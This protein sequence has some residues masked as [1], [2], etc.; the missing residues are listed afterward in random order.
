MNADLSPDFV[1]ITAT[2]RR[3]YELADDHHVRH[4]VM[5]DELALEL[6]RRRQLDERRVADGRLTTAQA[7][8]A[9]HVLRAIMA[10]L[11]DDHEATGPSW[12]D[13]VAML[14][15]VIAD[16]RQSWPAAVT[17][18][19]LQQHDATRRLG[20][21]EAILDEYWTVGWYMRDTAEARTQRAHWL[22]WAAAQ[23]YDADSDAAWLAIASGDWTDVPRLT[24]PAASYN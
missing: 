20:I 18:G 24:A 8:A 9:T 19:R 3:Y 5:R 10:D 14:R 15:G 13:K 17:S 16:R 2:G 23:G 11:E 7:A 22:Q 21:V 4:L 1:I 6:D 12:R